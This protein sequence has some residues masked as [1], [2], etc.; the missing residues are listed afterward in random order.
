[1]SLGGNNFILENNVDTPYVNYIDENIVKHN[2]THYIVSYNYPK[3]GDLN[4]N[5]SITFINS[6][7]NEFIFPMDESFVLNTSTENTRAKAKEILESDTSNEPDHIKLGRWVTN[8][9]KYSLSYSGID[10]TVDE[11]LSKLIGVCEHFTKLYNA[12]LSSIGIKAVYLTG[13]AIT[14]ENGIPEKASS[15][16]HAW[17]MAKIDGKWK[18]FDSTWGLFFDKFP[19]SHVFRGYYDF[20]SSWKYYKV[21]V[22]SPV[23][24]TTFSEFVDGARLTQLKEEAEEALFIREEKVKKKE[25]DLNQK[26]Y[27]LN[28]TEKELNLRESN[29][30]EKEGEL[31]EK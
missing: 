13:Y 28:N 31:Y 8:N 30:N 21:S 1:M 27:E 10:M 7:D 5:M 19:I 26:E 23:L 2:G 18:A 6:I 4:T 22:S 29:I 24:D 3:K 20:R 14:G 16:P 9:M 15:V 25:V 12:L 17:T 11:I